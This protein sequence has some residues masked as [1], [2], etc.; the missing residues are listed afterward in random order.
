MPTALEFSSESNVSFIHLLRN[1][2]SMF[3]FFL[4]FTRFVF[5]QAKHYR[6]I[7]SYT[8]SGAP[9]F[10]DGCFRCDCEEIGSTGDQCATENGQ[11]PCLKGRRGGKNVV[12]RRCNQCEDKQGQI[13]SGRGCV[14][15]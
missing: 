8:F 10:S 6:K 1:W 5:V 9:V 14:G 2:K 7:V 13:V 15:K 4:I 3:F 12:G 11:C